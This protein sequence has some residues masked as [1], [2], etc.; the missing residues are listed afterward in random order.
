[1]QHFAHIIVTQALV[2]SLPFT[3]AEISGP[4]LLEKAFGVDCIAAF[5]RGAP[6]SGCYM[7]SV[8]LSSRQAKP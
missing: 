6:A 8:Y 1:M 3:V 5:V 4:R 2:F 7:Y